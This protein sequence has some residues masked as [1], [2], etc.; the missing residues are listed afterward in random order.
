MNAKSAESSARVP[1]EFLSSSARFPLKFRSISSR[2][3]L[4]F[5]SSSARF[6]LEFRSSSARV[7][8]EFLPSSF[9]VPL[10]FPSS[11]PRISLDFPS[12]LQAFI[13]RVQVLRPCESALNAPAVEET[14]RIVGKVQVLAYVPLR[15]VPHHRQV[16]KILPE[17]PAAGRTA[18]DCARTQTTAQSPIVVGSAPSDPIAFHRIH[19]DCIRQLTQY[20]MG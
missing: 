18:S 8:P 1:L 9:Q 4:D 14:L 7:P 16:Q 12:R 13:T 17:N 15:R 11:S 10:D 2:V 19:S 20:R 3:P 6:P 5:L